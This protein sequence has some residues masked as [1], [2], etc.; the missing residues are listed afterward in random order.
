MADLFV[1]TILNELNAPEK[2]VN[3]FEGKLFQL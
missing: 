1:K 3:E 2:I